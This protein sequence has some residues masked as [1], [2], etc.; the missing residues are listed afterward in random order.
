M[1]YLYDNQSVSISE[2]SENNKKDNIST[3]NVNE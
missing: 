3:I 2:N 1:N